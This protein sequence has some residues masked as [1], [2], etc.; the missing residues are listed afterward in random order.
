MERPA[1]RVMLRGGFSGG[2]ANVTGTC[3]SAPSRHSRMFNVVPTP[4][5]ASE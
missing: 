3:R 5:V 2:G 4:S 1:S